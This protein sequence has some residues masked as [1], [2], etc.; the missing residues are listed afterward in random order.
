M[1]ERNRTSVVCLHD[2][3][4]L[5]FLGVDPHDGTRYVFLPGGKIEE[6]ES[7][8]QCAL[9][10]AREETGFE[11][12]LESGFEFYSVYPFH[13]NNQDYLSRTVFFAGRL[14]D[15][16]KAPALVQDESYNQGVVWIPVQDIEKTF[17]YTP[18]ILSAV[19]A[20]MDFFKIKNT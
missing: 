9:R 20:A 18:E 15:P 13:W 14:E 16:N 5:G 19:T 17:S 3:K 2:D 12:S 6:N 11:V 8:T 7:P 4:I 10:E 1:T